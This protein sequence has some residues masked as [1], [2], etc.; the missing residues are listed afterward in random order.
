MPDIAALLADLKAPDA[1]TRGE[2]AFLL[3]EVGD[4]RATV[5]LVEALGAAQA[6]FEVIAIARALR[7]LADKRAVPA[8]VA[9]ARDPATQF[10]VVEALAELAC[11]EALP[12]FRDALASRN[13]KVVGVIGLAR[14]GDPGLASGTVARFMAERG[15]GF[16]RGARERRASIFF[17]VRD[18]DGDGPPSDG[19]FVTFHHVDW[20]PKPF[21]ARVRPHPR[22]EAPA[23]ADPGEPRTGVV[24]WF[25]ATKGYGF[26]RVDGGTD[27]AFAHHREIVAR[28]FRNLAPGDRVRFVC[29]RSERGLRACSIEPLPA[30]DLD[31]PSPT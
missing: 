21:A 20:V 15:F 27:D 30:A 26:V 23:I 4:R 5:A 11:S 10:W 9:K 28:G 16:L 6:L 17:H 8:L 29:R 12:A 14:L 25:D 3:G 2:A 1:A 13:A 24:R 18:W 22:Q 7:K 19:Q 31:P